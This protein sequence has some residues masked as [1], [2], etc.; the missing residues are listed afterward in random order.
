MHKVPGFV[1][2][3]LQKVVGTPVLAPEMR[4]LYSLRPALFIILRIIY[5]ASQILSG[6]GF[7]EHLYWPDFLIRKIVPLQLK[8][9][10]LRHKC[11]PVQICRFSKALSKW[12]S[13]VMGFTRGSHNHWSFL[14]APMCTSC[15]RHG[16][17]TS[18]FLFSF[19]V[20]AMRN[21]ICVS[22]LHDIQTAM[23]PSLP[24]MLNFT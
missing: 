5:N 3:L 9:V 11:F 22:V 19:S 12:V 15:H 16:F 6:Y 14:I 24:V 20:P 4:L 18:P 13:T 17:A 1:A 8:S 23:Q 10:R 21:A 2:G 7:N